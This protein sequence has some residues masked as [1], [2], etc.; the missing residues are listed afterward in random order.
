MNTVSFSPPVLI[1]N[2][3]IQTI[4]SSSRIRLLG[5]FPLKKA[6]KSVIIEAGGGVRLAGILSTPYG[7]P[8]KGIVILLHGWEGSADSTYCVRTADA[9]F[10]SGYSVFRL[11]LRDHGGSHHLNE[12]L[13]YAFLLDEVHSAVSQAAQLDG[14]VPA[15]VVG[16]SLGGNFALRIAL[17]CGKQPIDNLRY[18][19]CISPVLDPEKATERIDSI[20]Y[21]RHYFMQKWRRSL[22]RKQAC[23]PMKYDFD[24]FLAATSIR[25]LTDA[26]LQNYSHFKSTTDYFRSYTLEGGDLQGNP[27]PITILTAADDPIIPVHDFKHLTLNKETQLSIQRFGGHNGFIEGLSMRSWYEDR[28]VTIFNDRA[29]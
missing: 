27:I 3:H 24:R 18:V 14:D 22:A 20:P 12:G 28:I 2:P 25:S 8:R 16:F 10:R 21:I 7:R 23:F 17:R 29:A 1:R 11:N 19:F 5:P 6:Q 26:L 15:F 13:F 9:L 4:L